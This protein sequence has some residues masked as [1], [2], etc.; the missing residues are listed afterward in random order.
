M[1]A[2][3]QAQLQLVGRTSLKLLFVISGIRKALGYAG[4]LAFITRSTSPCQK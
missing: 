2:T 4:T 3:T 1:N